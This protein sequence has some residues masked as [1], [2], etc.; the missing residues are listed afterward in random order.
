MHANDG[1]TTTLRRSPCPFLAFT[2]AG[3]ISEKKNRNP[4]SQQMEHLAASR[5]VT[6]LNS[7]R[8]AR[9]SFE[10]NIPDLPLALGTAEKARRQ[11]RTFFHMLP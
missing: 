6:L 4:W 7:P 10:K 9:K 3:G 2:T 1:D 11:A 5:L 8:K